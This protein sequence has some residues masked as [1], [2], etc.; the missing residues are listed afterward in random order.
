MT[1]PWQGIE[2]QIMGERCSNQSWRPTAILL[3][4]LQ[5]LSPA[6]MYMSTGCEHL[7]ANVWVKQKNAREMNND[8]KFL[9]ES[10]PG[11]AF[12]E[13]MYTFPGNTNDS[14]AAWWKTD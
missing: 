1:P 7:N 8:Q 10:A 9:L 3:M 13:M 6:M 12:L 2:S 5:F 14:R 11:S 4:Q